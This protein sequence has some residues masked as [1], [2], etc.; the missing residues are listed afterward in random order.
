[1]P[2]TQYI[3]LWPLDQSRLPIGLR[4]I[5]NDEGASRRI[6]DALLD[7]LQRY[8]VRRHAGAHEGGPLTAM[9]LYL[10]SWPLEPFAAN[11]DQPSDRQ[12]LAQV[13]VE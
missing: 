3:E 11:L 1:V 7:V 4:A 8:E 13:N 10:V 6:H 5:Y 12:L 2:V 9:R